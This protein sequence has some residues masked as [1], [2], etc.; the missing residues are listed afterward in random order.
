MSASMPPTL[1]TA[2]LNR[3]TFRYFRDFQQAQPLKRLSP[4]AFF[5][6][7]IARSVSAALSLSEF[8]FLNHWPELFRSV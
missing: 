2:E 6:A 3:Q 8:C 4:H 5:F 1:R 7:A